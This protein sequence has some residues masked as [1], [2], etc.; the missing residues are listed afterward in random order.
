VPAVFCL[1][2]ARRPLAS[3]GRAFSCHAKQAENGRLDWEKYD[4]RGELG[5]T[6][7]QAASIK[8]AWHGQSATVESMA[9]RAIMI[10]LPHLISD[11]L[12]DT[13]FYH[14]NLAVL[15]ASRNHQPRLVTLL[16]K[17]AMDADSIERPTSS[18]IGGMPGPGKGALLC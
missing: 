17:S 2:V 3:R 16:S 8:L 18:E 6:G 12:I 14:P 9:A 7:G 13:D 15:N 4:P 1:G 5:F 10:R 11:R